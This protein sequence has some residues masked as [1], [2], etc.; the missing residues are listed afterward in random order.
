[1][2]GV[3]WFQAAQYCRWLSEQEGIPEDEM[4]YPS[5]DQI[6]PGMKMQPDYLSRTGYRLPTEVEWEYACRAHSVTSRHSGISEPLLGN[7]AWYVQNANGRTQPVGKKMPNDYGLFDLYGNALEWCQDAAAPH[8]SS[9]G[10][11]PIEDREDLSV[12]TGS[13][14]RVLRGGSCA[15]PALNL[16]SAQ[17]FEPESAAARSLA[18]MRVART[19][20]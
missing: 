19:H 15:S 8:P 17:R 16:R 2:I 14:N 20:H 18:G 4:C 13:G 9:E 12:I 10:G 1:M 11:L 5:L 3:S 6:K 7:Y